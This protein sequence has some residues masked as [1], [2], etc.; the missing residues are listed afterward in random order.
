MKKILSILSYITFGLALILF[1]VGLFSN[2]TLFYYLAGAS[3]ILLLI[4]FIVLVIFSPNKFY[5]QAKKIYK[6]HKKELE[7][8]LL[9][10]L[11]LSPLK[12]TLKLV[13][14]DN[15]YI[16]L[17]KD[18]N[19]KIDL[20]PS[21]LEEDKEYL[22]FLFSKAVDKVLYSRSI[23]SV[24]HYIFSGSLLI[25]ANCK[26]IEHIDLSITSENIV[27]SKYIIKR[28]GD[29]ETSSNWRFEIKE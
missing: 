3:L 17:D 10:R 6:T 25:K 15:C 5:K 29:I 22:Y 1:G 24:F 21:T 18:N 2:I 11:K 20:L 4:L 7:K 26:N 8:T 12:L 13:K 28:F 16:L 19:A 27:C 23:K 14:S 9:N